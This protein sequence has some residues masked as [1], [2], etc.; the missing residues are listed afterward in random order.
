MGIRE[1][2][3]VVG[4]GGKE[5][6]REDMCV[7]PLPCRKCISTCQKHSGSPQQELTQLFIFQISL[8]FHLVD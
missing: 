7:E 4:V 8:T 2:K 6:E 1:K 5:R 3:K